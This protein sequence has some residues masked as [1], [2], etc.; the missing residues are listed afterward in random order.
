MQLLYELRMTSANCTFVFTNRSYNIMIDLWFYF[1][2]KLF[3]EVVCL[4]S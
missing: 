1:K 4:L 3:C 2:K